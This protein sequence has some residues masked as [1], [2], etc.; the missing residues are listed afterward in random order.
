EGAKGKA[1]AGDEPTPRYTDTVDVEADLPAVPPSAGS[2]TRSPVP[3]QELPVSASVVPRSLLDAQAAFVLTDA[4]K[5]VSGVSVGTGF[6]VFDHFVIRGFD[7]LSSGLVVTDGVAEPEATFYPLYNVRQVE[8]VKGP[9]AF[10]YGGNP[11]AGA[12]QIVRKQPVPR[13]FADLSLTYG[14]FGTFEGALD[15]NV[16]RA[17]GALAFRLNG[18]Y[19]GTGG[20]R[21]VGDGSIRAVNPALTW[22]PAPATRVTVNLEYVRSEW[23]PDTGLPFLG[24]ALAGVDRRTSYQSPFDR[25]VQDVYRL[26]LDAEHRV[27]PRL[28][29]RNRIYYTALDWESAGT[30]IAGAFA[31]PFPE[32]PPAVFRSLVLL[33][34]RQTIL[35]DQVEGVLAFDTGKVAH[36]LL[37]GFELSRHADDFTQEVGLLPPIA[38]F[39]PVETAGRP[40]VTDPRFAQAGDARSIVCAPYVVDRLRI[41]PRLQAFVGGRFDILD[42]EDEPSA[43]QRDDNPL[44][45]LGGVVFEPAKGLSLYASGGRAF[46]PPSTQVAGPREPERSWQVET[47]AKKTFLAGKGFAALSLYQLRRDGIAIPDSTGLA[48]Q[49]GDQRS[50]GVEIEVSAEAARGWVTY[51]SYA[52]TD[53]ELVRF[54]EVVPLE[55]P[56]FVVI[57]RSGNRPPFAPRHLLNVWTQKRFEN[58]LALAAGARFVGRQLVGEDNVHAVDDYVLLDAAVSYRA[59]RVH[60]SLNLKNLTGAEYATRGF[61]AA[62]AIPGRPL[63]VLGRVEVLLGSR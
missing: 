62:S 37:A 59:G 16:A 41:T 27:S 56:A 42:Y 7:S 5:N 58:G 20:Y 30:L 29:L 60:A 43:T 61:G 6:G 39:D 9:A 55:P 12:V 51:A 18:V 24:E 34:D 3:V 8:V 50:R 45:P 22:R 40:I 26:R 32:A 33:D 10:L 14:R 52:F 1:G 25:S 54:A 47:G 36:E 63:E 11:L 46:A 44:S 13:R 49:A 19:Q 53:A 23:P 31:L 35:G 17:D 21:D 2:V 15:A 48:R 4:L 38:V 28:L 57:D